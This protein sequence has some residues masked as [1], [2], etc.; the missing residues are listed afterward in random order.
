VALRVSSPGEGMRE[1][2]CP[3][4]WATWFMGRGLRLVVG[5]RHRAATRPSVRPSQTRLPASFQRPPSQRAADDGGAPCP[6][7]SRARAVTIGRAAPPGTAGHRPPA[8]STR[9]VTTW[10]AR[11]AAPATVGGP[12]HT[13]EI[14]L[15]RVVAPLRSAVSPTARHRRVV[16]MPDPTPTTPAVGPRRP[17]SRP[18]VFR[19]RR[20]PRRT[21]RLSS[22]TPL[23]RRRHPGAH[24]PARGRSPRDRARHKSPVPVR[25]SSRGHARHSPVGPFRRSPRHG[26]PPGPGRQRLSGPDQHRSRRSRPGRHRHRQRLAWRRR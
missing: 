10:S 24:R 6:R 16:A 13:S 7:R 5:R 21:R 9:W 14:R 12:R 17:A 8:G 20:D 18:A 26:P 3:L 15:L 19:R 22:A 25:R 4:P 11:S 2:R 1:R 23:R